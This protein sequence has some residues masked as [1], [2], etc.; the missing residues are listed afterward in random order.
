[1]PGSTS[2]AKFRLG[3]PQSHGRYRMN[4]LWSTAVASTLG[5]AIVLSPIANV[6]AAELRVLAGGAMSAVWGELKPKFEQAS[7]HKLEIFFGTTPNLIKEATSGK[8]FDI[9][10]VPV[11]VMQDTAARASFASGP[12]LEIARVGL[13]VAVRAGARKPVIDTPEALKATLLKAHSIASIPESATGYLI[14]QVFERLGISEPMK[15]KMKAQPN[16]AQVV[17]VVAKA[18]L[19]L[20][21]SLS[22]CSPRPVSTWSVHSPPS[23][24]KTSCSRRH[25]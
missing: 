14:A 24:N 5:F 10:I 3:A 8:R 11:D 7:G 23:C 21:C 25:S 20:G 15:A 9:G 1:M 17:A 19:N 6:H 18:R 2:S 4:K 22:T 16:P 12:P 13:G